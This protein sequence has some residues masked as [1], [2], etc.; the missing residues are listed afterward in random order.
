MNT[1]QTQFL[2][3]SDLDGSLLDH[4]SYSFSSAWPT[5]AL[6][7]RLNIP[8]ILTSSKTQ[9]EISIIRNQLE[10]DSPFIVENGAAVFLPKQS[11]VEQPADTLA[12]DNFWVHEATQPRAHWLSIIEE[13]GRKFSGQYLSFY[14]AGTQGIAAITGL[15]IA[16]SEAANQRLYSEPVQ[17]TGN[18]KDKARFIEKLKAA[19]ATV[20]Q[21]GRFL[22]VSGDCDKG[23]ALQ[24]LKSLYAAQLAETAPSTKI[25]DI[26][27][28]D[29]HNDRSM[30]EAA[31]AALLVRS[32]VHD[33]PTI[34]RE[35]EV[36]RSEAIGPSGWAEGV[37]RWL[38]KHALITDS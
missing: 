9:A 4:H 37:T 19:G 10:N 15:S 31:S 36:M 20:Q 34:N 8:L 18:E 5:V 27:I 30:L 2:V 32:P 38:E 23:R 25:V 14:Q 13:A 21:G 35:E 11:Y 7:Q 6:L 29:S 12:I 1:Q 16:Q 33:F 24:W 26:A 3:F 28:G 17:W 22:S